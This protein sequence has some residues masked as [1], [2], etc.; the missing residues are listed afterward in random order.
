MSSGH[1]S[2]SEK[3]TGLVPYSINFARSKIK[4][5]SPQTR[6][7]ASE[8]SQTQTWAKGLQKGLLAGDLCWLLGFFPKAR[9]VPHRQGELLSAHALLQSATKPQITHA[10]IIQGFGPP[11]RKGNGD[12]GFKTKRKEEKKPNPTQ[13][14]PKSIPINLLL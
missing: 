8:T 13:P 14:K 2:L 3:K 11:K 10:K 6:R 1:F 5:D 12:L 7:D 4:L 9:R